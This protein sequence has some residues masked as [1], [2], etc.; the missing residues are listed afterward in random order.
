MGQTAQSQER[1]WRDP[2]G[3]AV[4]ACEL[5]EE[6][7]LGTVE[8]TAV[9][10]AGKLRV[11]LYSEML[12][13]C[14]ETRQGA[15][16]VCEVLGRRVRVCAVDLHL[17]QAGPEKNVGRVKD[18]FPVVDTILHFPFPMVEILNIGEERLG[19]ELGQ[20]VP[21]RGRD[22]VKGVQ[23]IFTHARG[24]QF[25]GEEVILGDIAPN[26]LDMSRVCDETIEVSSYR[27]SQDHLEAQDFSFNERAQSLGSTHELCPLNARRIIITVRGR[28]DERSGGA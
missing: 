6:A 13:G 1:V 22:A 19:R 24:P 11:G 21:H 16:Q 18:G 15:N 5:V 8:R 20:E 14:S 4:E 2:H 3:V 9:R 12:Q 26:P 7:Q 25:I 27:S 17:L 28:M 10:T 23:S